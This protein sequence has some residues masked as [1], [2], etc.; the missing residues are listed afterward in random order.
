[1]KFSRSLPVIF[2]IL[3]LAGGSGH[4]AVLTLSN[5]T[6]TQNFNGIGAS[7]LPTGWDV[8]TSATT[9]SLGTV[10]T[11]T[12][13]PGT[14][15]AWADISGGFKNFASAALGT[16]SATA[17]QT[18][19]ANRALGLRQSGSVGDP[20]GSFSFN[21]ASTGRQITSFSLDLQTL[22]N[23]P[24]STTYSIQYGIGATPTSFTTLG[25][26]TTGAFGSTT[27]TFDV[28]DFGTSLNNLSQGWIR[29]ATLSASTGSGN[30][31]SFAIDNFVMNVVPEPGTTALFGTLGVIGLLRRRR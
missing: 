26:Y 18:A 28:D 12:N 7:P 23:Q 6:Y 27:V 1:M 9:T 10:Q 20:G 22:D 16:G 4:A 2:T 25:T 30:R 14:T 11:Y 31:D 29:I 21:F 24:R 13:T 3:G 19:A 5:G 15:T 8:R 17:A